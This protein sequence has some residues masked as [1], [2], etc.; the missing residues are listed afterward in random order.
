MSLWPGSGSHSKAGLVYVYLCPEDFGLQGQ[1]LVRTKE[2]KLIPTVQGQE[3]Q[4]TAQGLFIPL[5]PLSSHLYKSR[6]DFQEARHSRLRACSVGTAGTGVGRVTTPVKWTDEQFPLD[7]QGRSR[8]E[9]QGLW[10]TEQRPPKSMSVLDTV[11]SN[12]IYGPMGSVLMK[13]PLIPLSFPC[14]LLAIS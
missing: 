8:Y 11:L 3:Q 13:N 1:K 10:Q 5:Q 6:Q 2:N 7:L 4:E 9:G 12:Q 14:R